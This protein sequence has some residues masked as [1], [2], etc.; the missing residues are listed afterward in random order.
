[1]VVCL[2][3]FLLQNLAMNALVLALALR[4]AGRRLKPGRLALAAG[5][6]T[7]YAY[8]SC[9]QRA[10]FLRGVPFQILCVLCMCLLVLGSVRPRSFLRLA[11][12]CYVATALLG[13][14]GFGLM[15]LMGA[16]GFGLLQALLTA[17]LGGLGLVALALPLRRPPGALR[18]RHLVR[19]RW[20]GQTLCLEGFTD[21]GNALLEPLSG[22]PVMLVS[23]EL[24][25]LPQGAKLRP[26]PFEAMGE[27]GILDAFFPDELCV[28][29]HPR[30]WY[31]AVYP[32]R[33]A[34]GALLPLEQE[35]NVKA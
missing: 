16:R 3:S 27:R 33:L 20:Q 22:L 1:M 13:G 7:A 9:L 6:G 24:L 18:L 34:C 19:L 25:R 2:E 4:L 21:T 14:T 28:D 8:L 23:Q 12:F 29:G 32:G 31:V 26:V 10:A 15:G 5:L 11:G 30:E 35:R 17:L